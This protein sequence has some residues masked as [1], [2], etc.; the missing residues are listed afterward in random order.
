MLVIAV[1]CQIDKR[2]TGEISSIRANE[3][4]I[5]SGFLDRR[6]TLRIQ[7]NRDNGLSSWYIILFSCSCLNLYTPTLSLSSNFFLLT[8]VKGLDL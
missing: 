4:S 2:T 5:K 3:G 8:P 6:L 1:S 7:L